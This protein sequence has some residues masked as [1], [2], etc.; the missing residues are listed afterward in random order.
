MSLFICPICGSKLT[1]EKT[2]YKCSSGHCFDISKEGY[3]NLLPPNKKHSKNP[4]DDK[5][6]VKA[7]N[8]FLSSDYY[9]PLRK[10]LESIFSKYYFDGMNIFDSGCG[11]G[12]YTLG[13][14]S[15]LV[16][17]GIKFQIAGIDISKEACKR[18]AKRTKYVEIAVASAYHLP[19]EDDSIDIVLNCFSPMCSE[20]FIRI[21]KPNGKL[22]YV[23]PAPR[24]LWELKN[25]IYD[26]P[27][28]NERTEIEYK[29]FHHIDTK[30]VKSQ[31][32]LPN[33][34]AITDLFT[35]TP[36]FWKTPKKGKDI[37]KNLS[38]LETEISF[39]IHIFEAE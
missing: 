11:E 28:E 27:Y 10:E 7:R 26:N 8:R 9:L 22:I 38:E 3:V 35:M 29:G 31:I 12:Y 13:I 5:D 33:N 23:V 37:L 20:E 18:A 14:C 16:K 17:K 19:V 30:Y 4:G 32:Y 6:M 15:A 39:D 21:L 24:H 1:I 36:Y 34:E 2:H 25:A